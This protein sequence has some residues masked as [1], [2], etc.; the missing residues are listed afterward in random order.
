MLHPQGD[1][2]VLEWK[3]RIWLDTRF[4]IVGD[5]DSRSRK[6]D[7]ARA[8][9]VDRARGMIIGCRVDSWTGNTYA[10]QGRSGLEEDQNRD[11]P[12]V[13]RLLG[14]TMAETERKG[15]SDRL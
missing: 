2:W 12:K 5:L 4:I 7:R 8:V 6:M 14:M 11:E 10:T 3:L 9:A 1:A 13:A 15:V